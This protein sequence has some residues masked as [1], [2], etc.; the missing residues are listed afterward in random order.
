MDI[1][2]LPL[3]D[4]IFDIFLPFLFFYILLYAMLRKSKILGDPK[5]T[6]MMNSLLA[7]VISALSILSLYSLGFT[8]WLPG[9][10]AALAVA[11]FVLLFIFGVLGSA[12]KKTTGY[13]SGEAFK[14]EDEKKF[15]AGLKNGKAIWERL[16]KDS[17]NKKIW[18]EM[19]TEISKLES[20]A[21]KLGKSLYDYDWYR[22]YKDS[23]KESTGEVEERSR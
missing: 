23:V 16:K 2:G 4:F 8:S 13:V 1:F 21:E 11:A 9:F 5:E 17:Q 18:Q 3:T 7:L 10:G 20:L 22:E 6:N 12:M 15:D 14:T 19:K